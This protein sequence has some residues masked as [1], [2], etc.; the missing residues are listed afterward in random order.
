MENDLRIIKD[1]LIASPMYNLSLSSKELFHSNL[2]AWLGN[3]NKTRLFFVNVIKNMTDDEVNLTIEDNWKVEREDKN[4]DLC[5]KK[6]NEYLLVIENKVKSIPR[7]EQLDEYVD[8]ISKHYK[9]VQQSKKFL[10]LTLTSKFP[11]RNQIEEEGIWKIK[12]YADLAAVIKSEKNLLK[13]Y[14]RSLVKDY[15]MFICNLN[16]LVGQWQQDGNNSIFADAEDNELVGLEKLS[17]LHV[18][19]QFS[20]YCTRIKGLI[21]EIDNVVVFDRIEK[22]DQLFLG[23]RDNN[24]VYIGVD[25]GFSNL[26]KNGIVDIAI[27]VTGHDNP[28]ILFGCLDPEYVIKIQVEGRSY[29]HVIETFKMPVNLVDYGKKPPYTGCLKWFSINPSCANDDVNYGNNGIF[30]KDVLYPKSKESLRNKDA[31]PF[32]SFTTKKE[33]SFIYQSKDICD[34]ATVEDVLNNMVNEL[35]NVLYVLPKKAK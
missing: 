27:P 21:A 3:N 23:N 12:T 8:K 33:I 29:R 5:I 35:K 13:G 20:S 4:F 22:K 25:W 7:K 32:K 11:H 31:W 24:K 28:Q 19:I 10:L 18:K 15:L 34:N 9:G 14:H 6:G 16:K 26:G 30:K 2:L 17:D 1:R